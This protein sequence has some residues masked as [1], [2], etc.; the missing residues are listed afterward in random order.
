MENAL[1]KAPGVGV[2]AGWE[3]GTN[4]GPG[5]SGSVRGVCVPSKGRKFGFWGI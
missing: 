4:I 3:T 2:G 5:E 1:E